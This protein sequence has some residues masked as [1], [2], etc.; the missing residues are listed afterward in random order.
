MGSVVLLLTFPTEISP[1]QSFLLGN[2]AMQDSE[3]L[4]VERAKVPAST[5]SIS[6]CVQLVRFCTWSL[7]DGSYP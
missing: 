5:S 4:L 3:G 1:F 2:D 6:L 7:S